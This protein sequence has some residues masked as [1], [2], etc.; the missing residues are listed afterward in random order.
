[1]SQSIVAYSRLNIIIYYLP[2]VMNRKCHLHI[3]TIRLRS[4]V[5][6]SLDCLTDF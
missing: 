4:L 2:D 3:T 1:M 5:F 6:T